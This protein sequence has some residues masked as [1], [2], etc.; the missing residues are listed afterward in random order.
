MI[1]GIANPEDYDQ[2]IQI[3][4]ECEHKR[5]DGMSKSAWLEAKGISSGRY[6][7][8][9]KRISDIRSLQGPEPDRNRTDRQEQPAHAADPVSDTERCSEE[10][11]PALSD[12]VDIT[13]LVFPRTATAQADGRE[14]AERSCVSSAITE[15]ETRDTVRF[16][17]A[18]SPPG[19]SSGMRHGTSAK[20]PHSRTGL[21]S[22]VLRG[23][24]L[25]LEEVFHVC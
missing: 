7:Y 24:L 6:Y 17:S 16:R 14:S 18:E 22:S 9:R 10:A 3:I 13:D 25:I 11:V 8:W 4:D 20:P 5:P 21:F 23:L 15:R 12:F 19:V 1:T 2:W